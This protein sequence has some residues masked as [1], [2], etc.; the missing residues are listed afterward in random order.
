MRILFSLAHNDAGPIARI[1]LSRA[2]HRPQSETGTTMAFICGASNA[3]SC[4]L[5][6]TK[7]PSKEARKTRSSGAKATDQPASGSDDRA[8][9]AA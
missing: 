1:N 7:R 6:T 9:R 2:L 8:S 4:R 5:I 3:R